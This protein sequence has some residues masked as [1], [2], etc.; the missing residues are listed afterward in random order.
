MS[1]SELVRR[2]VL[3]AICDDYE[4]VDQILLPNVAKDGARFG[5]AVERPEVVNALAGLIEDGLAKT[6]DLDDRGAWLHGIPRNA[7]CRHR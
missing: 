1:R 6:Y 7:A 2:L 4:N 5:L 3:N